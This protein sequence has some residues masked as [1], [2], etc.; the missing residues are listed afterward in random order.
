MLQHRVVKLLSLSLTLSPITTPF[1]HAGDLSASASAADWQSK[2]VID[3]PELGIEN[4]P[5]NRL[6]REKV[7]ALK[8]SNPDF[9]SDP[10]WPHRLASV[11]AL[12]APNP[13]PAPP[14]SPTPPPVT[15]GL[16]RDLAETC[17]RVVEE[18]LRSG[19]IQSRRDEWFT[20]TRI[21]RS[22]MH[23]ALYIAQQSVP[24]FP[25]LVAA[26]L[27]ELK[28]NVTGNHPEDRRWIRAIL[29]ATS[30]RPSNGEPHSLLS[31]IAAR[32]GE[33]EFD[34]MYRLL[35]ETED[36]DFIQEYLGEKTTS[37]PGIATPNPTRRIRCLE[38]I[39][40]NDFKTGQIH[41]PKSFVLQE[42]YRIGISSGELLETAFSLLADAKPTD[43]PDALYRASHA[44]HSPFD[45]K[46]RRW[47]D[48][49]ARLKAMWQS[50]QND[51]FDF[52]FPADALNAPD[53]LEQLLLWKA[54]RC[55]SRT[56]AV[57][58]LNRVNQQL[59]HGQTSAPRSSA[60][61]LPAVIHFVREQDL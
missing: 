57:D 4:S 43:W 29:I 20:G 49:K 24:D 39:A 61:I 53:R 38:K 19:D 56:E 30:E 16:C 2:A 13:N 28:K 10:T 15:I 11:L 35:G 45:A 37:S 46:N 36:I 50:L 59:A 44:P 34:L 25:A 8:Q 52:G 31:A 26:F 23:D 60:R 18:K 54:L 7:A 17:S 55:P 48:H 6:F 42:I 22:R 12:N 33:D 58:W 14:A 40:T 3:F 27:D 32:S 9:F 21:Q 51:K 5:L 47:T 1:L 41:L